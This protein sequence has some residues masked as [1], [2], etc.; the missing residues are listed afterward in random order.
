MKLTEAENIFLKYSWDY[1]KLHGFW[2]FT[3]SEI[4]EHI[5]IS[6]LRPNN[7]GWND[8]IPWV[9]G[10][11]T[12][13]AMNLCKKHLL[14]KSSYKKYGMNLYRLPN[15]IEVAQFKLLEK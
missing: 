10:W 11:G 4:E 14:M 5:L 2:V 1:N 6:Y 7:F 15:A 3:G 9:M 8:E 13:V 12:N